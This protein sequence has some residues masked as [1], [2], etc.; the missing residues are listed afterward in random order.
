L[1]CARCGHAIT[2]ENHKGH[3]YYS[4]ATSNKCG[5][6]WRE[7]K[8]NAMIADALSRFHI[9]EKTKESIRVALLESHEEEAELTKAELQKLQGE[10]AQNESWLHKL[11]DDRL[12][13]IVTEDFFKLK[14]NAIQQRQQE[15]QSELEKLKQIN[16]DYMEEAL[17]ILELMQGMRNQWVRANQEQRAKIAKILILELRLNDV[18]CSI[19]WNKPF[20][21][22]YDM[23]NVK[24]GVSEGSR[25]PNLWIHS[26][27]L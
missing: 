20:D 8:I 19:E 9:S 26:P 25:T 16:E 23:E 14:Y 13:A 22:L 5:G 4:C 12:K 3:T 10:F 18:S 2:A 24:S 21:L 11:Y 1:K 17:Q 15:I 27:V 6:Y 7:E